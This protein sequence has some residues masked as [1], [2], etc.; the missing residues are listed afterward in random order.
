MSD[1]VKDAKPVP[2]V[3]EEPV[4]TEFSGY[5]VTT[6][7]LPVKSDKGEIEALVFFMAYVKDSEK[8]AAERPLMFV[9]N[10]GPGSASLWL[11]L[12]AVGPKRVVLNPD[13][14]L[15]A[16]P[17]KLEDNPLSWLEHADLVFLDPVGTGYS[18]GRDE[19]TEKKFWGVE[20]DI[21]CLGEVMRLYLTRY[22]RWRSPLYLAGESYGTTRGAGLAGWLTEQGMAL[23]GVILISSV[24]NFQTLHFDE[25]NDLPYVLFLPSYAITARYHGKLARRYQN[26]PQEKFLAE[27]E[28]FAA[29]P[30]AGALF[31]G[32]RLPI[33]ERK[34]VLAQLSAYTG[35]SE[36]FLDRV[37]LR[38]EEG[39]FGAELLRE[40]GQ[41]VGRLDARLTRATE[42][43]NAPR[44]G[45]D[46]SYADIC[47]P[48][49]GLINDYVRETLGWKTDDRYRV[50]DGLYLK[51]KWVEHQG[52]T[53][54]AQNLKAAMERNPH[55][56]VLVTSGY[57]DLA[58]PYFAT[59]YTLARLGVPAAQK[60]NVSVTY[61]DAGH[62]MYIEEGSWK[63]LATD[64]G[65]FLEG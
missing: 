33:K 42:N 15:P 18:R 21:N 57:Y 9:F 44:M 36:A 59:E 39:V 31:A 46:P 2:L 6:G 20:A 62:M 3:E 4:V 24:L 30:Y 38:I 58:T 45:F 56:R 12:G 61:Y 27:V 19:E 50:L 8:D 16:P 52:Y 64:V 13:G 17:Y 11:H 55:L 22:G 32:D 29:G 26:M 54:T 10:G 49:T 35:L 1:E 40:R 63:K 34:A 48:Y 28:R 60:K 47:Q 14:S 37:N 41:V 23:A 25:G 51:W 53:D 7:R 5:K 65:A 43:R